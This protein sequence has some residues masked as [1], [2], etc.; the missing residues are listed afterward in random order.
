MGHTKYQGH[1]SNGSAVRALTDRKTD[2]QT[3]GQTDGCYQVHYLPRFAVDNYVDI[4]PKHDK[5]ENYRTS[6]LMCNCGFT[7]LGNWPLDGGVT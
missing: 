3:N 1:K 5:N 2:G 4:E 7:P 6:N